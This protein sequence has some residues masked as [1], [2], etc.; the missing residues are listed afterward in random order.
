M[1]IGLGVRDVV[2]IERLDLAFGPGLTALT[3]E[4]GVGKSI[5][6]Y[7]L[8]L[9]TPPRPDAGRGRAFV[10]DQPATVAV[11]R[12]LG[13]LLLEVHGQ[14]ETVGLLDAVTHRPLLDAFGGLAAELSA[15]GDG[16]SQ[17][18]AAREAA[19]RLADAAGRSA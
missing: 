12:E 8:G 9:A 11:L 10:N 4:T 17:W 3:G 14:H 19:E 16:W 6:L 15:V 7:F 2:L 18:R 13:A 5:I 1:L